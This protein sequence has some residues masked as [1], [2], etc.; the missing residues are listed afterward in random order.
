MVLAI[1]VVSGLCSLAL[2]PLDTRRS[3]DF[4]WITGMLLFVVEVSEI[5]FSIFWIIQS[6]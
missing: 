1:A 3:E 6:F 4:L 2:R 5:G